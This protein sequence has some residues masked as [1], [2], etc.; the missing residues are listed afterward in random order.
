MSIYSL[1]HNIITEKG[2]KY[3]AESSKYHNSKREFE[4]IFKE[5]TIEDK[6]EKRSKF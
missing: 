2:Q 1:N 4:N 6:K 5:Q 3:L